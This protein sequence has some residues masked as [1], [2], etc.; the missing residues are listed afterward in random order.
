MAW[1]ALASDQHDIYQR[2]ADVKNSTNSAGTIPEVAA[3]VSA[4]VHMN[5]PILTAT[6]I[7]AAEAFD[8][9]SDD[10]LGQAVAAARVAAAKHE[11]VDSAA[12]L[13]LWLRTSEDGVV[14]QFAQRYLDGLQAEADK[15]SEA[16][17]SKS[18]TP[19]TAALLPAAARE[20]LAADSGDKLRKK[21]GGNIRGAMQWKASTRRITLKY[22]D[23]SLELLNAVLKL[24]D[25]TKR[26]V[27]VD[28]RDLW[29][30]FGPME[31]CG[32]Y[33]CIG[34]TAPG[35]KFSLGKTGLLTVSG[36][37]GWDYEC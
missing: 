32:M 18:L 2:M 4:A 16:L 34:I 23:I 22:P 10:E 25:N 37:Y 7:A 24:P 3:K 1:D 11:P 6:A 21:I 9:S 12:K 33:G 31:K 13:M 15:L 30:L 20:Q 19:T 14:L 29:D 26:S 35:L 28:V 5:N 17:K 36:P 8:H 27:Q